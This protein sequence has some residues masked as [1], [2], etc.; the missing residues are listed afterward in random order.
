MSEP[1]STTTTYK[2]FPRIAADHNARLAGP[3]F[4]TTVAQVQHA[5]A[6]RD[7]VCVWRMLTA[8]GAYA[9][10]HR[11]RFASLIGDD[12]VLGPEWQAIGQALRGLLNGECA[13][14]DGGTVDAI[15]LDTMTHNGIDTRNL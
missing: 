13:G 1:M 12:G 7:D 8:W 10:T 5:R 4:A 9:D 2:P 11:G 14:L 15:I 6:V 3:A